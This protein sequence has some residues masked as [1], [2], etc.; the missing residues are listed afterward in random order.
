MTTDK[1]FYEIVDFVEIPE[2]IWLMGK[3]IDRTEAAEL[4]IANILMDS[5]QD[6]NFYNEQGYDCAY[7]EL[8][9]INAKISG[10]D[11]AMVAVSNPH[12][13]PDGMGAGGNEIEWYTAAEFPKYKQDC[14]AELQRQAEELAAE[15]QASIDADMLDNIICVK[16]EYADEP[17]S[18]M[19]LSFTSKK[20]LARFLSGSVLEIACEPEFNQMIISVGLQRVTIESLLF[21]R[22]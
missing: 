11:E 15:E 20:D 19:S 7:V 2:M 1:K 9:F 18:N 12:M 17:T 5:G 10:F 14:A 8:D 13:T 21:G 3:Q 22:R 4:I 6:G 16:W